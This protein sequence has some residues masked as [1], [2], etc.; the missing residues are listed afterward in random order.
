MDSKT[1]L[2]PT[3]PSLRALFSTFANRKLSAA[4]VIGAVLALATLAVYLPAVKMT[5]ISFDDPDYV[6]RNP[7]VVGGLTWDGVWWSLTHSFASNWHPLTW[8]SHML[9]YQIYG[10]NAGGHHATSILFHAANTLLV[11]FVLREI[12]GALWR[13]ALVA[14]LFALHPLHVESVAWVAERK[15]VLSG[16]F[17]LLTLLAYAKYATRKSKARNP[18]LEDQGK[19]TKD[20]KPTKESVIA[21]SGH[22]AFPY[23]LALLLFALGL[24]SKPMLVTLPFVM[25][26]LDFWPLHRFQPASSNLQPATTLLPNF[27]PSALHLVFEKVPFLA[28]AVISSAVTFLAQN[29][30]GSTW[31]LESL[32]V[33]V[34]I[35]NAVVSYA[36]YL[37]KTIW[38]TQLSIVYP[39]QEWSALQIG[40][41]GLILAAIS[42]LVIWQWRERKYLLTGWLW[43]LGMLVPVIGLVQVGV[44]AMA[45]RYMYLPSIGLFIIFAWSAAEIAADRLKRGIVA[46][47][48]LAA[49]ITCLFVTEGQMDYWQNSETLFRHA[50][51]ITQNNYVAYN[52]L[53][54]H[55]GLLGELKQ[56]E[57]CY[58]ATLQIKP[59]SRNAWGDLAVILAAEKKTAE[60]IESYEN[61]LRIAPYYTAARVNLANLLVSQGKTND[62]IAHLVEAIQINPETV[63]AH[64]S[65]AAILA[66]KGDFAGATEHFREALRLRPYSPYIRFDFAAMLAKERKL[67]EAAAEY[68]TALRLEPRLRSA[69]YALG[70]L[71]MGQGELQRAVEQFSLAVKSA[72]DDPEAHYRLA[73]ALTRQGDIKKAVEHYR[74][75]LRK[76]EDTPEALNNLAWIL[77]TNPDPEVRNGV[78]AVK[79]AEKACELTEN[80]KA[81]FVGTL[82]AAYAEA[83][84]FSDAIKTAE[85]ARSLAL[86]A[87]ETELAARNVK[88]MELYRAQKPCRDVP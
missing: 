38:P 11:F 69:R 82:A 79:F 18:K 12:T 37:G 66:E 87:N 73:L 53:G 5:F 63:E 65:L 57:E 4:L 32:P 75:G 70:D 33:G 3:A 50:L 31:S 68:T 81:V 77:A 60:A 26:L 39:Y 2:R 16:F 49:V 17:G 76:V 10:L 15:D 85:R 67:D 13:S 36:R 58:R 29:R 80:K 72:P 27:R 74:R 78:E 8:M 25:L 54:F 55:Y 30:G 45:D 1:D 51:A 23:V 24:M 48:A 61:A 35:G 42:F 14:A 7:R 44:Q 9:D 19:T 21:S 52:N 83:N 47:L 22:P 28:F 34:R 6:W 84:R 86:A 43:F 64:Q 71:W 88:L 46:T 62:A 40:A 56:A 41:A 59:N 20:A